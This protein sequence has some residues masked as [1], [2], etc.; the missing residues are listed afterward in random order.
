MEMAYFWRCTSP[1]TGKRY[2]TRWRMMEVEAR[3]RLIDPERIE[4]GALAVGPITGGGHSMPSGL[5]RRADGAMMPPEA[6]SSPCQ[7]LPTT[8]SPP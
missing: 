8:S 2:T 1:I 5:V 4:C 3:V 6:T 7:D